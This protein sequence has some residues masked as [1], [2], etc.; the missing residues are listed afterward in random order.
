[1]TRHGRSCAFAI[2]IATFATPVFADTT[3]SAEAAELF[4][5]GRAALEQKDYVTACKRLEESNRLERAVGTLISLAQCEEGQSKLAAARQ[6][7]QEAADL[8]DAV[9]DRLQ[10]G[11]PAREKVAELDKKIARLTVKP[12]SN[13]PEKMTVK[14][15]DV[16]LTSASFGSAL[17]LDV[18]KHVL[19]VSAEGYEPRTFDIVLAEGENREIEVEPGAALPAPVVAPVVP[20]GPVGLAPAGAEAASAPAASNGNDGSTMRTVAYVVGGA[21]IVGLGIGSAFGLT[22]S[23]KWSSAQ[24]ACKP[25]AC[26]PGSEAQNE[27]ESAASAGHASTVAFVVGSVALATGIGLLVLAPSSS[28]SSSSSS[29]RAS[30]R[31]SGVRLSVAPAAGGLVAVGRF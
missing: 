16:L 14:R 4:K 12:T 11:A 18:G 10:R 7:W 30:S 24:E 1:M 19:V 15:D 9:Q 29:S 6:H 13:A 3:G 20:A 8:A 23:S 2:A 31:R 22:A 5:Q 21:G 25:G 28:P 26:G 17:P 27:K